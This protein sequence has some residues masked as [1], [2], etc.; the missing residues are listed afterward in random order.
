MLKREACV[1]RHMHTH[2][3]MHTYTHAHTHTHTH[4]RTHTHTHTH[5][6]IHTQACVHIQCT[7]AET[8][9]G[10]SG[11]SKRPR[12]SQRV[13]LLMYFCLS[14]HSWILRYG[15]LLKLLSCWYAGSSSV[16]IHPIY[17]LR[18]VKPASL[19][20][21]M[22]SITCAWQCLLCHV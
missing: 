14:V 6:H 21:I 13:D 19:Q 9:L 1:R 3:P 18:C 15:V 8:L 4:T 22:A 17:F 16:V 12:H 7:Q 10:A 5:T 20:L 2:T 11:S